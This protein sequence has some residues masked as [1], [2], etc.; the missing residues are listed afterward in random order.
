MADMCLAVPMRIDS[1]RDDGC[2]IGN[3]DGSTHEVNLTLV[4]G[5]KVGDYVI[6][7]TGFAIERLDS[8]QADELLGMLAQLGS[9]GQG[10]A[11]S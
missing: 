11:G 10:G 1:I 3:L 2:G 7:H 5:V 4:E 9:G 8:A 6:V